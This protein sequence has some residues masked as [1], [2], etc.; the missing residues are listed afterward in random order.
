MQVPQRSTANIH[1]VEDAAAAALQHYDAE[2]AARLVAGL[3]ALRAD[4]AKSGKVLPPTGY[5]RRH[6]LEEKI[7]AAA[8]RHRN[9]AAT[10]AVTAAAMGRDSQ[11]AVNAH[12]EDVESD[13]IDE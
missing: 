1:A 12:G 10:T 9:P 8:Q 5:L 2:R 3:L 11:A 4:E 6:A 13:L 7:I